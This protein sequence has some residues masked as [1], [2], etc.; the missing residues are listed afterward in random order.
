MK[1]IVLSALAMAFVAAICLNL[2]AE[3]EKKKERKPVDR[4]KVFERLDKNKDGSISKE[5]FMARAKKDEQK[6]RLEK[7]F[8]RLDKD[9][10]GSISKE[11]FVN[12]KAP[13]KKK[14][15]E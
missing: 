1:K 9:K 15:P 2:N 13:K 11:E 7:Q 10:N 4:S 8:T 14:K 5:E 3:E 12:V 6:A